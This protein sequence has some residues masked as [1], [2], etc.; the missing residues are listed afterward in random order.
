MLKNGR[1]Q[2]MKKIL[3]SNREAVRKFL[4]TSENPTLKDVC[5]NTGLSYITARKHVNAIQSGE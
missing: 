4:S 5:E 2:H 1:G 3:E